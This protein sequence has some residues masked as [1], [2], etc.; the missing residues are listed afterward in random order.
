[1]ARP[2]EI[3]A[4]DTPGYAY[5]VHMW[6]RLALVADGTSGLRIVDVSDPSAPREIG[7]FL[8]QDGDVRGIDTPFTVRA[9]NCSSE[10]AI[11]A[12][13]NGRFLR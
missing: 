5:D 11:V 8:P 3:S 6:G 12:S 13:V 1:M 7:H 2:T 9:T 4:Y 10:S